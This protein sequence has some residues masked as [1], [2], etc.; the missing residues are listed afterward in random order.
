VGYSALQH[1]VPAVRR[2]GTPYRTYRVGERFYGKR[3]PISGRGLAF[4]ASLGLV[5]L[6][7]HQFLIAAPAA[8]VHRDRGLHSL[9]EFHL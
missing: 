7:I 6:G 3:L 8:K 1:L 9:G 5:C 2:L 4:W